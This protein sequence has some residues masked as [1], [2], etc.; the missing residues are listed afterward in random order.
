M[1]QLL[2]GLSCINGYCAMWH[3]L[4]LEGIFVPRNVVEHLLRELDPDGCKLR[5]AHCLKRRNYIS[6]GPN[7][8]WHIVGYDKLKPYGFPI[9]SCIDGWSRKIMWLRVSRTIQ[10]SLPS[11][12]Y[13]QLCNSMAVPKRLE[14]TVVLKMETL[15]PFSATFVVTKK[16][17]FMGHH[18]II[19]A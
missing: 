5:K 10:L 12:T 19:S 8:C 18:H 1:H 7:Y 17:I 4:R 9:H 2:D 6:M 16:H 11:S 3:T 15:L 13:K 14:V